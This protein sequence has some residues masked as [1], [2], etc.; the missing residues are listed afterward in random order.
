[1]EEIAAIT[2]EAHRAGTEVCCHVLSFESSQAVMEALEGGVDL[3]DHG[4]FLDD[5]CVEEMANRKTWF[6]PMFS[7]TKWHS[8]KNPDPYARKIAGECF[9]KTKESFQKALEA[10]VKISMGTDHAYEIG[11]HGDEMQMMVECGMTPMQSIITST[12]VASESLR[13]QDLV[14]TIEVGKEA[15]LLVVNGNPLES[16]AILGE[17]HYL[18]LVM[19]AGKPVA[20][21]MKNEFTYPI[22][23]KIMN[24]F[25]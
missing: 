7:V 19:Q 8:E 4:T 12:R 20:G 6:S 14:G 15:D 10:G 11:W 13:M 17:P 9:T 18:D 21:P 1:M 5:A 3:I 2:D 16:V 24:Q 25:Y 22:P 23:D